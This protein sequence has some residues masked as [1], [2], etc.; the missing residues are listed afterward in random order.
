[1]GFPKLYSRVLDSIGVLLL[2]QAGTRNL[3]GPN[4]SITESNVR[5][6]RKVGPAEDEV[7]SA[8]VN[9]ATGIR[10]SGND[11]ILG[12]IT[13]PQQMLGKAQRTRVTSRL[14]VSKPKLDIMETPSPYGGSHRDFQ[15]GTGEPRREDVEELQHGGA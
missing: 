6:N 5:Q 10:H 9:V 14:I 12:R 8:S 15:L 13:S 11:E 3:F 4:S 1:M 7:I 2:P